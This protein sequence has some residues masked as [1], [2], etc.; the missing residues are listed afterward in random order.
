MY[1]FKG[2]L[3]SGV[4][5]Y[6][7]DMT[8]AENYAFDDLERFTNKVIARGIYKGNYTVFGQ[9]TVDGNSTI[10]NSITLKVEGIT[11]LN[12]AL[13]IGYGYY[14]S[15]G[16]YYGNEL[17]ITEDGTYTYTFKDIEAPEDTI[18]YIYYNRCYFGDSAALDVNEITIEEIPSYS[19]QL[20]YDGNTYTVCYN[21]PILEDYT[22]MADRTWFSG[23]LSSVFAAKGIS[24]NQAFVFERYDAE[25]ELQR[26]QSFG[27][28][29]NIV[30]KN[31]ISY[32]T[33]SKYN[34][35]D[36]NSGTV[37]DDETLCV[38]GTY[39][40]IQMA[41]NFTFVGCHG[42]ILL[43]NRTLTTDEIEWVKH[44]IFNY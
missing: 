11:N 40:K 15:S 34:G 43:F 18:E 32:Q 24:P 31:G 8:N 29:N 4:G 38:G 42:D 6:Q 41:A 33:K 36:I 13:V 44:N 16:R 30:I 22:V 2:K 3:N 14:I 7:I 23:A 28:W 12:T 20:C 5:L 27:A 26:T 9:V 37:N 39:N 19:D 10:D 35:N 21:S 25:G 17:H 1:G